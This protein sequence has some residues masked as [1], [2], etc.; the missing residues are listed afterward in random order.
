M[1]RGTTAN[2][3]AP[4][5]PAAAAGE[6]R[7]TSDAGAGFVGSTTISIFIGRSILTAKKVE[8]G[9]REG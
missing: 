6:T 3:G 1:G 4:P 7:A 9:G 8:E 5:D 2:L